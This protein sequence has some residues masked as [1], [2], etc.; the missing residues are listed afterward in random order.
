MN[1][2]LI[3]ISIYLLSPV[4]AVEF[5]FRISTPNDS[6]HRKAVAHLKPTIPTNVAVLIE[7]LR[8]PFD[9]SFISSGDANKGLKW[10][11]HN[12]TV[13]TEKIVVVCFSEGH[14][15]VY[16][17]YSR[18]TQGKSWDLKLEQHGEFSIKSF[19]DPKVQPESH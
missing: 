15:D 5:P 11:V 2:K 13:V 10:R 4:T 7:H 16:G 18:N 8:K 3:L 12:I 14:I 17:V 1:I 19:A 9:P 6:A